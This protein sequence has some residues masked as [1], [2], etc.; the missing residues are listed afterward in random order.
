[1]YSS[2]SNIWEFM[3]LRCNNIIL[4]KPYHESICISVW[5]EARLVNVHVFGAK[6]LHGK[7]RAL[8]P[9]LGASSG[10]A[11]AMAAG[12]HVGFSR[13]EEWLRPEEECPTL[14]PGLAQDAEIFF[15]EE[16]EVVSLFLNLRVHGWGG[17]K[18]AGRTGLL[19]EGKAGKAPF[20]AEVL[21]TDCVFVTP[22]PTINSM[23]DEGLLCF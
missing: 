8:D 9:V 18:R 5:S 6:A 21:V 20:K 10:W 4:T 11:R 13:R 2:P 14:A 19:L 16:R 3:G 17:G 23:S 1:M 15:M 12:P 22:C 7:R